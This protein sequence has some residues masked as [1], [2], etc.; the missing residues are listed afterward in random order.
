MNK[1]LYLSFILF[2]L[3]SIL[4][5]QF[6][7]KITTAGG[8]SIDHAHLIN[9]IVSV[10]EHGFLVVNSMAWKDS[11]EVEL[12]IFDLTRT[13]TN[14][15]NLSIPLTSGDLRIQGY[16]EWHNTFLLFV[17][18]YQE[19]IRKN[20]LYAYQYSL[21]DLRLIKKQKLEDVFN[22]PNNRL[23]FF[24][25]TS[26]NGQK[27]VISSWSYTLPD[28]T[29]KINT[30]VFDSQF[31]KIKEKQ[32]LFPY[33]NKNLFIAENLVDNDGNIYIIGKNHNAN[34]LLG[35][36][37][38]AQADGLKFVLA[39]LNTQTNPEL[40]EIDVKKHRFDQILFRINENA[41]LIGVGLFKKGGRISYSGTGLFLLDPEDKAM[42]MT[43]Q[44][45]SKD[46][47]IEAL[48][49]VQPVFNVSKNYFQK[50]N[51]K[52]VI[53]KR[54]AYYV[55]GERI[56]SNANSKTTYDRVNIN[57]EQTLLDMFVIKLDTR[58][59]F[60]WMKRIPKMQILDDRSFKY[61][62]FKV[63]D[64]ERDLL[65][66]YNDHQD[67][68]DYD[69]NDKLKP[70][71]VRSSIP[72]LAKISYSSGKVIKRKLTSLFGKNA[73]IRPYFCKRLDED[74]V[75]MFG[76]KKKHNLETY[77]MKIAR[78]GGS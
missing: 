60:M 72:M 32:Y 69:H 75:F 40:Y 24:Y 25:A 46:D 29:G 74:R 31:R 59:K 19:S 26:P 28:D 14:R 36:Q 51:I 37:Q 30:T 50:A 27:L 70:A 77:R 22:P 18:V 1:H 58:G 8:V 11:S 71:D 17:S 48:G 15:Q 63:I 55:I 52:E 68:F 45:L 20:E 67:N 53:T 64:R 10:K 2:V 7:Q 23:P 38:I 13:L 66:F 43:T 3:P 73:L 35:Y 62:S 44:E 54:N 57:F 65:L 4:C 39:F 78:L 33:Q 41:E 49:A 47:F 9:D 6:L 34:P 12:Q 5:A 21:P 16:Q 42:K 56:K 61:F 76:Q